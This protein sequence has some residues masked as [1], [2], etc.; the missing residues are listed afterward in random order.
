MAWVSTSGGRHGRRRVGLIGDHDG[1]DLFRRDRD[2]RAADAIVDLHQR[3]RRAGRA[4]GRDIDVVQTLEVRVVRQVD[5]DDHVFGENREARR[6]AHRGGRHDMA[7]LGDGHGLD[8]GDVRQLELL[9]AQLLDGFRQVLVD[10]HHL[11]GVDRLA[12]GA[13]DLKR[14]ASR[15]HAGFGQ[16][17]VEVV[18]QAGA[19][20]QGDF[21]RRDLGAF[22]Q[23]MGYGLGF[24]GA[25]EAAHADGHAVLDQSSGVSGAHHLIQQR[26]QANTITV[27]GLL[28]RATE[29]GCAV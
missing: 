26:R 14:H 3:D 22:G 19:G 9:V 25:G 2:G 29:A 15:Q 10:E 23:C 16:L 6:V 28:S 12:Q 17:F 24:A 4:I 18:A 21:Q 11:A 8:D 7:L 13:V 27:H 20:H 1:D 5:L